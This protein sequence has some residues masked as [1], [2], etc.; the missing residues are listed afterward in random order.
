MLNIEHLVS[1]KVSVSTAM[2]LCAK[3]DGT[4]RDAFPLGGGCIL[5]EV[6]DGDDWLL[7]GPQGVALSTAVSDSKFFERGGYV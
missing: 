6:G 5:L 7:A 2:F 3:V 4:L 1:R